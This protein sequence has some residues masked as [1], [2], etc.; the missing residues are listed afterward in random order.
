[1]ST[2][3]HTQ[4]LAALDFESTDKD[5]ET[6]RIITAAL[7]VV[8][9]GLPPSTRTWLLAPGVPSKP[10]AIEKHKITDEHAAAHG[11]PAEEG[12]HEIATA[13][14]DAVA[15]SVPVV[16]HNIGSYDLNLLD[17]ETRRHFGTPLL[18]VL[19][20]GGGPRLTV[21]DTM[22]LDRHAA[23]YRRRVSETQG[24]YEMRTSAE[25]Y[26]LE[27]DEKAAHGAAYDALQ[28]ARVAYRIGVIAHK[29]R[30]ERPPWVLALRN[31]RGPYEQFDDLAD[32][33]AAELHDMQIGWA[34]GQAEGLRDYFARTPGKEHLADG[35]RTD[36]PLIPFEAVGADA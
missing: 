21:L 25:T 11:Q 29:P 8:G 12:I 24:P 14:A 20:F 16:G 30:A 18:D 1:M 32:L 17:R 28:S 10:E 34:R 3:W 15:S 35:V 33:S 4:R 7:I 13:L 22:T 19:H 23:P 31:R 6:A 36:W 2:P 5:P 27:W 9:G 26:G